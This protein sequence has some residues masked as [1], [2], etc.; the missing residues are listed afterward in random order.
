MSSSDLVLCRD[1][2]VGIR[3]FCNS[4][5]MDGRLVEEMCQCGKIRSL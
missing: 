3:L 4:V 1:C 2:G 5:G